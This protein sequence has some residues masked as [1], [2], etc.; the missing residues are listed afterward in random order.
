M[1]LFFLPLLE[2]V[3]HIQVLDKMFYR[4]KSMGAAQNTALS[5]KSAGLQ[6]LRLNISAKIQE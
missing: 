4:A 2:I 1:L 5:G 3:L 6:P